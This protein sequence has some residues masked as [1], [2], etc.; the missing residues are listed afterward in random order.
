[1]PPLSQLG[2]ALTVHGV[3]DSEGELYIQG[4]VVGRINAD[5]LILQGGGYIEGD[6]VARDVRIEGRL[7]GRVFAFNV[8]LE[9]TANI[10]G[11]IFHHTLTVAKGATIDGRMPWRPLNYFESFDQLPEVQT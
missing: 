2:R 1:M 3:L 8:V 5:R 10:V 4:T 9:S 7:K 11:R 6:V